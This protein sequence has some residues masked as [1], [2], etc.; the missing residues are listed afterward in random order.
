MFRV[1]TRALGGAVAQPRAAQVRRCVVAKCPGSSA[2]SVGRVPRLDPGVTASERARFPL[3]RDAHD[4]TAHPQGTPGSDEIRPVELAGVDSAGGVSRPSGRLRRSGCEPWVRPPGT[5][6][7]QRAWTGRRT[8]PPERL[9]LRRACPAAGSAGPCAPGGSTDSAER[10]CS[11][12]SW[13]GASDQRMSRMP[14]TWSVS[15]SVLAR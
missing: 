9:R 13:T 4:M 11:H 3:R 2:E 1:A 6:T 7:Q 14:L 8:D 12:R 15:V 5:P 10:P